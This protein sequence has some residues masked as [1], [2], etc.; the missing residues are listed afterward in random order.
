MTE[1]LFHRTLEVW[2]S[3]PHGSTRNAKRS[4]EMQAVFVLVIEHGNAPETVIASC[5]N[6]PTISGFSCELHTGSL[7]GAQLAI[8]PIDRGAAIVG[9]LAF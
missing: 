9:S 4:A 1:P 2:G 7:A 5:A 8:A 3:I 6:A